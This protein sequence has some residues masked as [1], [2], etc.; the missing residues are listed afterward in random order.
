MFNNYSIGISPHQVLIS[1][2][3]IPP[4]AGISIEES[5]SKSVELGWETAICDVDLFFDIFR[6]FFD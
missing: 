6:R 2:V 3:Y 4:S 1:N 5:Y